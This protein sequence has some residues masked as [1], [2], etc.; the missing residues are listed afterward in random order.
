MSTNPRLG[1]GL[2]ALLGDSPAESP[3][4]SAQ[5][6]I[7]SIS[8]DLLEPGPFQPR[9]RMAPGAM[10]ELVESIKSRGILQPLLARRHPQEADRFQII[11]GERRWR[12]AQQASLH[13]VPVLVRNLTD[14]EAMAASLVENLQRQDLNAI[15]EAE[16]YR[17]L[18]EEFGLTQEQLGAAVGK[19]RSHIANSIRLLQLPDSVR[20][21]V[22]DGA[23]TAGHARALLTHA[24]PEVAARMV[25]DKGLNVRQTEQL[26]TSRPQA[27]SPGSGDGAKGH[28]RDPETEALE[29]NLS[30]KLGLKVQIGFDG[31]G[32]S[33][34]IQYRS[35]DQLD[36]L[37]A[38]LS[39]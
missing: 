36:G 4:A 32:G 14:S 16:G 30:E 3:V 22:Q 10:A 23:L 7:Q 34:R 28:A 35:L 21:Q 31:R 9:T 2:A 19:S 25:I 12:A 11:A 24:S 17:R 20:A 8:I 6:A 5:G 26:I 18:L 39:K 1:R 37:I 38:L 29:R 33:V 27:A 15:E 13:D